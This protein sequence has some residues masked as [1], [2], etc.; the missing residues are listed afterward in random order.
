[1][2]RFFQI[3]VA[4]AFMTLLHHP[5]LGAAL[6][7]GSLTMEPITAYNFVVDSNVE[8]PSSVSPQAA[9]L[10]V[11]FTN[12]GTITLT[13][14]VINI[15]DY[16]G[17]SLTGT[18]GIFPSKTVTVAGANGYSGTFALQ[19]VG[20]TANATRLI[21][22][23]APG[24]STVQY[25][26][27]T[28]PLKDAAGNSVAGAAPDP[29]DDL[30]LDYDFWG[31][32]QDGASTLRVSKTTTVT[33]RNEI[34]A[35]AN[36]IAPNTTAAVPNEY[37][38]AIEASLGWRPSTGS[39]RVPGTVVS[40]GI[41]YNLGNVGAGFDNDLDL[42]P[43]R[44]AWMQPAGLPGG[45]DTNTLRLVKCY[46]LV[47]VKLN[48]GTERLIPFEDRLYFEKLPANNTGAVGLVW[49][50]YAPLTPGQTVFPAPYQ[51][52]ASGYDN[53]KFNGDFGASVGSITTP[54]SALQLVKSAPEKAAAGGPVP[55]TVTATNN[56][57]T[58]IGMPQ[59]GLPLV[60]E[61]PIPVGLTYVAGSAALANIAPAGRTIAASYSTDGGATWSNVEPLSAGSVNRLRWTLVGGGLLPGSSMQ[62]SFAATIPN[63]PGS[64]TYDNVAT[65]SL[66]GIGELA[67]DD[68]SVKVSGINSVGDFVWR[69]IDRQNDQDALEPGIANISLSLYHD[70]NGN[71]VLDPGDMLYDQT[72]TDAA[73]AYLFSGLPDAKYLIVIDNTDRDVPPGY[74]LPS[75]QPNVMA[76][77]LDPAGSN[78]GPVSLLTADF[79]FIPALQIFKSVS[80]STYG[81]GDLVTYTLDLENWSLPVPAKGVPEQGVWASALIGSRP[82]AQLDSNAAGAPNSTFA[83][84]DF[85][86]VADQLTT[87]GGFSIADPNGSITKVEVAIHAYLNTALA[88]DRVDLLV[89]GTLFK[90]FSTAELNAMQGAAK[91]L[92]VDITS[93][94][95]T[96]SNANLSTLNF[97]LK[98]NKT[99]DP[100]Y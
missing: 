21:P 92:Y 44:N 82:A 22:S 29:L 64:F 1:M 36:K 75:S 54:P 43:D 13:G 14:I 84:L 61:D 88:D 69:D 4:T 80:P 19:M 85:A 25:F 90:T 2:Y 23:L 34:S 7:D 86:N 93:L 87:S 16:D 59:Y 39:S 24:E 91:T 6:V 33:M 35:M 63:P 46:G 31:S 97:S 10:A 17:A 28:Y 18:P 48:D 65:S 94:R 95:A 53:E 56:D 50:E 47:I 27:V 83:R 72:V 49:Y 8:S 3:L 32:A 20:S 77:S 81:E 12:T 98:T 70:V 42:V 71:G 96:W 15:G 76:V 55:F 52:V 62:V 68:A 30:Q 41:W 5:Y 57:S 11:R 60:I 78:A 89:N 73:G 51:E 58:P 37:L 100:D 26:F 9:H 66:G 79:P 40:E 38:D 99:T 74:C 45:L 67:R